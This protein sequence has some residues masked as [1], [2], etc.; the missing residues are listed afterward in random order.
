MGEQYHTYNIGDLV[1]CIYDL[2]DHYEYYWDQDPQGGYPFVGIII[3]IEDHA[4]G[5]DK[6]G[7]DRLYIVRC[8]DGHVRFF[9]PWEIS[10]MSKGS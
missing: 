5:V 8:F 10:L 6:Y 9:A 3:A 7:Y 2:F 4:L 1:K